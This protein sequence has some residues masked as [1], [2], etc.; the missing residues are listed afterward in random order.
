MWKLPS[1]RDVTCTNIYQVKIRASSEGKHQ[2][3]HKMLKS[4]AKLPGTPFL[5]LAINPTFNE[6][7]ENDS[8]TWKK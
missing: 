2:V 3:W 1:L 7:F 6:N 8:A 4:R 5:A